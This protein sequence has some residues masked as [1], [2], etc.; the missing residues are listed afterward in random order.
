MKVIKLLNT[1]K[2]IQS[3]R[4]QHTQITN[5]II[6]CID[7]LLLKQLTTFE[8]ASCYKSYDNMH[9]MDI[10]RAHCFNLTTLELYYYEGPLGTEQTNE[11]DI[12]NLIKQNKQLQFVTIYL[13]PT[14]DALLE[15]VYNY[16]P[17][18]KHL[19]IYT[20]REFSKYTLSLRMIN[21]FMFKIL[22][23]P[24]FIKINGCKF[25][26][27]PADND[28]ITKLFYFKSLFVSK[29]VFQDLIFLSE[30]PVLKRVVFDECFLYHEDQFVLC[31]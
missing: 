11:H 26:H 6:A 16:C 29:K 15:A 2:K 14:T 18:I 1:C 10:I 7:P 24:I 12:I 23:N 30:S 19:T 4:F 25:G 22:P 9:T 20:N 8:W 27:H 5:E 31:K 28:T 13:N 21:K 17:N 3:L